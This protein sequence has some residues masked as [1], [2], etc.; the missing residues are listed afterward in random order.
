MRCDAALPVS[1]AWDGPVFTNTHPTRRCLLPA[2]RTRGARSLTARARSTPQL[3]QHGSPGP[4]TTPPTSA[5]GP[6]PLDPCSDAR[7]KAALR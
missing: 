7:A 3:E 6:L 2:L 4:D 5:R 1:G